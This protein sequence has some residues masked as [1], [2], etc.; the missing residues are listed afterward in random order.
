[1]TDLEKAQTVQAKFA[2]AISDGYSKEEASREA[3]RHHSNGFEKGDYGGIAL[4]Y[5]GSYLVLFEGR[6]VIYQ[7]IQEKSPPRSA[8]VSVNEKLPEANARV[9]VKHKH[10]VN[11]AECWR[12]NSGREKTAT[13]DAPYYGQDLSHSFEGVTH[14]MPMPIFSQNAKI[15]HEADLLVEF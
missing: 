4:A 15:N 7:E 8:W 6:G 11:E 10:G 3:I 14:W 1:M 2:K 5:C 13:W 12:G 9:I